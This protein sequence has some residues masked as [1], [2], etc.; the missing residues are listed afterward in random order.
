MKLLRIG[1]VNLQHRSTGNSIRQL[2]GE[3][4]RSSSAESRKSVQLPTYRATHCGLSSCRETCGDSQHSSGRNRCG[5]HPGMAGGIPLPPNQPRTGRELQ[6][7]HLSQAFLQEASVNAA[8]CD[9]HFE[10]SQAADKAVPRVIVETPSASEYCGARQKVQSQLTK[11]SFRALHFT[12][13]RKH[14]R[15]SEATK[16]DWPRTLLTTQSLAQ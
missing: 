2:S 12:M 8:D 1:S 9:I 3:R 7:F 14:S 4:L 11:H 16:P 15:S 13:M 6:V 5:Y 10:I